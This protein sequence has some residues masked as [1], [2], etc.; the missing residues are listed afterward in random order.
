M[1]IWAARWLPHVAW[2]MLRWL[3]H[4]AVAVLDGGFTQWGMQDFP[5]CQRKRNPPA[6][7][8]QG[9]KDPDWV[10]TTDQVE[11]WRQDPTYRIFDARTVER[12]RGPNEN[13]TIDPVAGHIPGAVSAPYGLNL[14]PDNTFRPKKRSCVPITRRCWVISL[15]KHTAG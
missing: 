1:T 10:V 11:K 12:Y 14:R 9:E 7:R 6:P 5:I 2:G 8:V 13:E 3:G 4:E 15:P